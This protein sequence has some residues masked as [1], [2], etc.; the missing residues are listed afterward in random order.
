M[1]FAR[2]SLAEAPALVGGLCLVRRSLDLRAIPTDDPRKVV[3]VSAEF[4]IAG[5]AGGRAVW[6]V[7][8]R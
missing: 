6:R 4:I 7:D 5:K 1:L 3:R 8:R 2:P